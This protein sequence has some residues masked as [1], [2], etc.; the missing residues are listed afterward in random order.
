MR[1]V[2]SHTIQSRVYQF[3]VKWSTTAAISSSAPEMLFHFKFMPCLFANTRAVCETTL[4]MAKLW[5]AL[6][7]LWLVDI[8]FVALLPTNHHSFWLKR[9]VLG[10]IMWM[11]QWD[12]ARV[13]GLCFYLYHSKIEQLP[14][15]A[16]CT[17]SCHRQA[18]PTVL[19]RTETKAEPSWITEHNE[20]PS[21]IP[22]LIN[23]LYKRFLLFIC[24]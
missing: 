20:I 10:G 9:Q 15:I 2:A 19:L 1:F 7:F 6:F 11:T 16:D 24:T 5:P 18:I 17:Q 8:D 4:T 3:V 21:P 23:S 22:V 13:S 12:C 14:L